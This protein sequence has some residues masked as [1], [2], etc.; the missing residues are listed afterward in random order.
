[1]A[2]WQLEAWVLGFVFSLLEMVLPPMLGAE[3]NGACKPPP[4]A[5]AAYSE[6]PVCAQPSPR[7]R[8]LGAGHSAVRRLPVSPPT[9]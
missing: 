6:T 2:V 1:M 9:E 3:A 8:V 7:Q 5:A 4:L